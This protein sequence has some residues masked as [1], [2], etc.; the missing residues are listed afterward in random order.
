MVQNGGVK[1]PEKAKSQSA[2]NVVQ[3]MGS[4]NQG[5]PSMQSTPIKAVVGEE[6][7]TKK[8]GDTVIGVEQVTRGA[9]QPPEVA[10]IVGED[11]EGVQ[12]AG[13]EEEEVDKDEVNREE[14]GQNAAWVLWGEKKAREDDDVYRERRGRNLKCYKCGREGHSLRWC[15]FTRHTLGY[16]LHPGDGMCYHC[17]GDHVVV[18]CRQLKGRCYG[19]GSVQHTA[20]RCEEE[21]DWN[22]M[23]AFPHF[24]AFYSK[25]L[26]SSIVK[27]LTSKSTLQATVYGST[28]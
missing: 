16:P 15:T 13:G 26:F 4:G 19:C 10:E 7:A 1:E 21:I 22:E 27:L 18:K 2:Q 28:D 20:D 8:P 6:D 24:S 3:E 25:G 11:A 9:G 23:A 5:P 17:G 14:G 12:V